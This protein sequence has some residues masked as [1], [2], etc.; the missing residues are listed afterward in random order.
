MLRAPV[1]GTTYAALATAQTYVFMAVLAALMST[2]AVVRHTR[3]NEETG[4]AEILASAKVGRYAQLTAALTLVV[5]ANLVLIVLI[6][7]FAAGSDMD[8][9]GAFTLG[10][11][12]G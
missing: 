4:R 1:H 2:L 10:L 9:T 7:G 5:A 3:Q 6:A 12:T 11:S 8:S